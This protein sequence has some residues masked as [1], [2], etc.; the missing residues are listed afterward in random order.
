MKEK[1]RIKSKL[2]FDEILNKC[3]KN[4]NFYFVLCYKEKKLEYSRYGFAVGKK[5]GNA[6]IRNRYKRILREIIRN[7]KSLFNQKY[8][9]TIIIRKNCDKINYSQMEE[10]LIELI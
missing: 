1:F 8:D 9:Y 6:V 5:I 2:E 10:K 3:H 7:N 4:K